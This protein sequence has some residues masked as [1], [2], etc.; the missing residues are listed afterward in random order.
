MRQ[1]STQLCQDIFVK[2]TSTCTRGTGCRVDII[3][4]AGHYLMQNDIDTAHILP[5]ET[6]EV[7]SRAECET[8]V[9]ILDYMTYVL[10]LVVVTPG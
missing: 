4:H 1:G 6:L 8:A 3:G 10:N 2:R 5:F 9:H 7:V